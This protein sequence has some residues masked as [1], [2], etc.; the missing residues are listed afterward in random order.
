[1]MRIVMIINNR[2]DSC[3]IEVVIDSTLIISYIVIKT[4]ILIMLFLFV[5]N[6]TNV[7]IMKL[8]IKGYFIIF[9]IATMIYNL[10][11]MDWRMGIF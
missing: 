4:T 3:G 1:M 9:F 10:L 2:L 11:L 6:M 7:I 5:F 8:S